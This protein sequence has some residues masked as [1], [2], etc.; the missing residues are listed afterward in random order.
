MTATTRAS[1]SV[2][3]QAVQMVKNAFTMPDVAEVLRKETD[4]YFDKS[5]WKNATSFFTHDR[6]EAVRIAAAY[7]FFHGGCEVSQADTMVVSYRQH[8]CLPVTEKELKT[9]E[10]MFKVFVVRSEG[11]NVYMGEN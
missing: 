2:Y 6:A 5:H 11:Y 10:R 3:E 4:A 8:K 7:I 1:K 9:H